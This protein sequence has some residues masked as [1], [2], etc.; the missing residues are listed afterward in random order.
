AQQVDRIVLERALLGDV[1][2]AGIDGESGDRALARAPRLPVEARPPLLLRLEL[3][4]EDARQIA[5]ILGDEEI[6]LHEALDATRPGMV[7]VA[8]AA[9]DFALPVE[10]EAVL[11]ALGEEVQVA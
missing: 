1:E 2:P 3:G 5:D 7:G 8:H 4:A 10:G 9:P 6:M 11:G